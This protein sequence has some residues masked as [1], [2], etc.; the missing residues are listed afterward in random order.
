MMFWIGFVCGIPA[1][2]IVVYF[3]ARIISAP[4]PPRQLDITDDHGTG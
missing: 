2:L 3:G 4:E 1:T